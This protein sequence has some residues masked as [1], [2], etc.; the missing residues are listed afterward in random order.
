M[1]DLEG[2][3]IKY[4]NS[5][6]LRIK[7]TRKLTVKVSQKNGIKGEAIISLTIKGGTFDIIDVKNV[8]DSDDLLTING[9]QL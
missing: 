3:S 1:D 7:I 6:S 5:S 8:L 2:A 4:K 9:V